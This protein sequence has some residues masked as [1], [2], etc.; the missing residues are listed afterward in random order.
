M[1]L[2]CPSSCTRA[3]ELMCWA[4]PALCAQHVD[5]E[6]GLF[7]NFGMVTAA[8]PVYPYHSRVPKCIVD[9]VDPSHPSAIPSPHRLPNMP[10]S[11]A[12]CFGTVLEFWNSDCH[13][14][15]ALAVHPFQTV[16]EI[17]HT[18]LCNLH[19]GDERQVM[20]TAHE[21]GLKTTSTIMFGH[22]DQPHHWYTFAILS[23]ERH[24]HV[25]SPCILIT[26]LNFIVT[27][28]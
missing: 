5:V 10:P 23:G 7:W 4:I 27:S 6:G 17:L 25:S 14:S 13:D 21:V 18:Y 1:G 28:Y 12:D 8:T 20:A 15:C 2:C 11:T 24:T 19:L 3:Y 9:C 16:Q 22:L 26:F